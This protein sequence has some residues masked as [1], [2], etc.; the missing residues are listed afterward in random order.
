MASPFYHKGWRVEI[1]FS[2]LAMIFHIEMSFRLVEIVALKIYAKMETLQTLKISTGWNW[3][4]LN[5]ITDIS[6][7]CFYKL[8]QPIISDNWNRIST[9]TCRKRIPSSWNAISHFECHR[10]KPHVFSAST[11][12]V[13]WVTVL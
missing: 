9:V 13:M 11:Q 7:S 4:C 6:N 12:A 3:L 10:N 5:R 8:W 1:W 2:L